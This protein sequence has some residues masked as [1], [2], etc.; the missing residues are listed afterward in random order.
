MIPDN[1][2]LGETDSKVRANMKLAE[3]LKLND[4]AINRLSDWALAEKENES[5]I[6]RSEIFSDLVADDDFEKFIDSVRKFI[7]EYLGH[8]FYED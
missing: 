2:L 7:A 3:D 8:R 5:D 6:P 4:R 1:Y